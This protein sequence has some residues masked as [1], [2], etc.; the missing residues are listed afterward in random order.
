MPFCVFDPILGCFHRILFL[1]AAR[2][3]AIRYCIQLLTDMPIKKQ[4]EGPQKAGIDPQLMLPA[5]L[6]FRLWRSA[7]LSCILLMG[8][9]NKDVFDKGPIKD[10]HVQGLGVLLVLLLTVYVDPS[11]ESLAWCPLEPGI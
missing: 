4:H 10:I 6:S 7:Q 11:G 8:G 3:G 5:A 9:M 2:T 1:L